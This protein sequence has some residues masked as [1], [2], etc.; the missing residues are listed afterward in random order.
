MEQGCAW[1]LLTIFLIWDNPEKVPHSR[2]HL[3]DDELNK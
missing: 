2:I 1:V 3:S